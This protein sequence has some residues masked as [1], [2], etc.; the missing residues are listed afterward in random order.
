MLHCKAIL[1]GNNLAN[2]MNFLMNHAPSAVSFAPPV[3]LQSNTPPLCYSCPCR[4]F[5][6]SNDNRHHLNCIT[7]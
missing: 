5:V 7:Y 2:E 4:K 1:G 3:D 6:I